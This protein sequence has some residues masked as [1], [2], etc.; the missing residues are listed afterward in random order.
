MRNISRRLPCVITVYMSL[1]LILVCALI[2]TL[3]ES[4]RV[5][6]IRAHLKS[7]TYMAEDSVFAGFAEPV[8][9]RYGVMMLWCPDS[10]FAE[11]F[12][13]Y[14]DANLNRSYINGLMYTDI[15]GASLRDVTLEQVSHPTDE[16]GQVFADQVYQYMNYY[17]VEDAAKRILENVSIFDQGGKVDAFMERI[18]SFGKTFQKV[19]DAVG[20]VRDKIN[21]AK[22]VA[23][24][25]QIILEQAAEYLE[26]FADGDED[27]ASDFKKTMSELKKARDKLKSRLE[28][29]QSAADSYYDCVEK[30]RE[31]VE[32]LES[33][34]ELDRDE[35]D[36]EIYEAV[37]EQVRDI[38][39]KC[40]DTDFDYYLVGANEDITSDYIDRLSSLDELFTATKDALDEENA[41]D[42]TS[43]TD[44]FQDIFSDFS[45]D[46]LGVNFDDST[47]EKEDDS[48]LSQ[49]S[50]FF[51]AGIL[52]FVAGE[53]SDRSI[54]ISVLPS[55]T[56]MEGS[57]LDNEK[58]NILE[59][60]LNKAIYGEYI[61][62]H[63]G[64]C[65]NNDGNAPLS[66]EAEYIL[67]GRSSDRDNLA[68]VVGEIVLIRTGCN[69]ISLLKSTSKKA[70]TYA[71][72][73][74]LAG[75]T[76][77]PIVIKIVQ[78]L[79]MTAW[80]LAESMADVKALIGG[81]KV[82]TIKDDEDWYI[83]LAGIKNFGQ[84]S[85]SSEGNERGLTYEAYLRLLLLMQGRKN[86]YFRTMDLIQANMCDQENEDFR[87][88]DC[89]CA[90]TADAVY[91]APHLFTT[92]PFTQAVL[93][94]SEG[95][96]EFDI[97][98]D[99]SY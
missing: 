61:L 28:D 65:S 27:A 45:L 89:I 67:G 56:C 49:V 23:K 38:R 17:L 53:V 96:Y 20:K 58:E 59:A 1:I 66:Y 25:P 64:N 5:S 30:A 13:Y 85:L 52:G 80:A 79:V 41:E 63:F 6:G 84:D 70:E 93:G 83:S 71:L 14:A 72:A 92:F 86:Q 8:F 21:K 40:A 48:F 91:T 60:S 76:G 18:E 37:E 39:Q 29:V 69:L 82:R 73:S 34:L 50:D 88:S 35:F 12:S 77:M 98:Q 10:E 4:A 54:D 97:C 19:E 81:H 74:S 87:I 2:F 51:K 46:N 26:A 43:L 15:Y 99:Y 7:V 42:I 9:D 16:G 22:A 36:P 75:F 47:V 95:R 55:K 24:D 57:D 32:E 33:V 90:A 31:A 44:Y 68:A 3:I 11:R 62:Q 78:I 94:I